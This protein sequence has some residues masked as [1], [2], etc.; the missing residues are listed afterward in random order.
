MAGLR[1]ALR[2][3]GF[4]EELVA[5]SVALG[6]AALEAVVPQH[7][8]GAAGVLVRGGIAEVADPAQRRQALLLAALARA[9]HGAPVHW[10]ARDDAAAR[11]AGAALEGP[12]ARLALPP[13]MVRC[14]PLREVAFDYLRDRLQLGARPRAAGELI[15]RLA[16]DAPPAAQ[17]RLSGLHCALVEDADLLMLDDAQAPLAMTAETDLSGDDLLYEQAMELA[18]ALSEG[19]DFVAD[20]EGLQLT[21]EG[22]HRLAELSVLL[23]PVWAVR[24]RREELVTSALAALHLGR[25]PRRRSDVLFRMTL[26]RFLGRYLHLAGACRDARGAEDEFWN[27]YGLRTVRAG[28]AAARPQGGVR[29]F[30]TVAQRRAAAIEAARRPGTV[31]AVRNKAERDALPPELAVLVYPAHRSLATPPGGP[32]R[33]VVA[34][35]HDAA[36]H[37]AQIAEACGATGLDTLLALEDDAV[38]AALGP[39]RTKGLEWMGEAALAPR[40]AGPIASAAQRG[41]ERAQA[42]LRREIVARERQLDELLAFSGR[43]G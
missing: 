2:R 4:T 41:V 20:D 43:A 14:S 3:D 6:R 1:Y 21:A 33:V 22:S 37:V 31:L 23:G 38:R 10:L 5:R 18:R 40:W 25:E 24:A 27:L 36:R 32:V 12:A 16:G 28:A 35:L 7:V 42:L 17:L 11:R 30:R 29:I 15:E 34:E 39:F 19:A 8:L 26:P 13:A 9:L